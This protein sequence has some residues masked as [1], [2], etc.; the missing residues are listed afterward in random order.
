MSLTE[1]SQLLRQLARAVMSGELSRDEYRRQRRVVID[2]YAGDAPLATR[3][4][5]TVA[6]VPPRVG[7]EHTQPNTLSPTVPYRSPDGDIT[8]MGGDRAARR[9]E[10]AAPEPSPPASATGHHDLWIGMA[11]VLLVLLAIGGMLAWF[12]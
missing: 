1:D 12:W 2:R 8:M 3:T 7:A 4:L 5:S 11:A 10:P 6:D 9:A